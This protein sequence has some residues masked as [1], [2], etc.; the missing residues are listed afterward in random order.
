MP[1]R[2]RGQRQAWC[3]K[4]DL[5]PGHKERSVFVLLGPK[6]NSSFVINAASSSCLQDWRSLSCQQTWGGIQCPRQGCRPR[7]RE[8]PPFR[9]LPLMAS[10]S[11]CTA[12]IAEMH[13]IPPSGL[14][15]LQFREFY[16]HLAI[17]TL[18]S[19]WSSLVPTYIS[20]FTTCHCGC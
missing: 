14:R 19:V 4:Q 1:G 15:M 9:L 2:D 18:C 8:L 16:V 10:C 6:N 17:H 7:G 20:S 11:R 13:A 5:P 12:A 3:E